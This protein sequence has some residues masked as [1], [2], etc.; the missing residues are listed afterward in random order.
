MIKNLMHILNLDH[1]SRLTIVRREAKKKQAVPDERVSYLHVAGTLLI[2][3]HKSYHLVI[4][5]SHYY[6]I[7]NLTME[8]SAL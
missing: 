5:G 8:E 7:S 3:H 6:R 4:I 1:K 2:S